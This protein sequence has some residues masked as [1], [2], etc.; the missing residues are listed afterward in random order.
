MAVLPCFRATFLMMYLYYMRLSAIFVSGPNRMSI[1]AC[2]AGADLV[3]MHL[4]RDPHLLELQDDLGAE[5][6]ELVGRRHGE[7]AL[8]VPEL[9]AEVGPL[10][11]PGVPGPFRR[12]DVVVA[13]LGVLVEADVVE[14]VELRLRPPVADVGDPGALQVGFR[15]LAMCRGSRVYGSRVTGSNTLQI[16]LRVGTSRTGSM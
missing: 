16:R 1:S 10:L 9:V 12:V 2:P 8:L 3:V 11:A 6:L 4:D 13:A 14:D 15:L 7:V 5:V